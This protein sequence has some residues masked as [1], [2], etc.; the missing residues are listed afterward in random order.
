MTA[1]TRAERRFIARYSIRFGRK[2]LNK[3]G[4]SID[5][6]STGLGIASKKG[7]KVDSIIRIELKTPEENFML[8]GQVRW[9][10]VGTLPGANEMGYEMG[11]A[12]RDRPR[13]YLK[14]LDALIDKQVIKTE[15]EFDGIPFSVSYETNQFFHSEYQSNI[16]HDGLFVPCEE[17]LPELQSKTRVGLKLLESMAMYMVEGL[18]IYH[19]E[20]DQCGPGDV[21]GFAIQIQDYLTAPKSELALIGANS[22]D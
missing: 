15:P 5:L 18:V 14:L 1:K 21:P 17:A 13:S 22:T 16:A 8:T 2:D 7:Y 3:V 20:L 12:L 11:I 10:K 6:S 4:F 19:R 9:V